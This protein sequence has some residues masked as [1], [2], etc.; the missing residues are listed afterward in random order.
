MTT[1]TKVGLIVGMGF[2]VLFAVILS[3]RGAPNDLDPP[4]LNLLQA[5]DSAAKL[6]PEAQVPSPPLGR[7]AASIPA[8]G[9]P[10][11]ETGIQTSTDVRSQ[12][13]DRREAASETSRALGG[14]M[15]PREPSR[16]GEPAVRRGA[17]PVLEGFEP[18]LPAVRPAGGNDAQPAAAGAE[19]NKPREPAV[20][21]YEV[22]PG[23]SLSKIARQ[24]YGSDKPRLLRALSEANRSR[25]G[26]LDHISAG[27]RIRVPDIQELVQQIPE[28][29]AATAH[30]PPPAAARKPL[31]KAYVVRDGDT[32]ISIARAQLGQPSRWSEIMDLNQNALSDPHKIRP[33]MKLRLPTSLADAGKS[34]AR[35]R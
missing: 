27:Q 26:S 8:A 2:I 23:D 4:V 11:Q 20:R 35:T 29:V 7:Q 32:L 25:I 33:G 5:E 22:K 15:V 30:K 12:P 3:N 17:A 14:L 21:E 13:A 31:A 6:T 19:V 28:P 18:V 34:R 16:S 1:E 24:F 10:P 9:F